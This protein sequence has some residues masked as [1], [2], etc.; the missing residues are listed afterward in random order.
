VAAR[1]LPPLTE[2]AT[3]SRSQL[4]DIV[5]S[6]SVEAAPTAPRGPAGAAKPPEERER[7]ARATLDSP[8][9]RDLEATF[10]LNLRKALDEAGADEKG[11]EAGRVRVPEFEGPFSVVVEIDLLGLRRFT[12]RLGRSAAVFVRL[13]FRVLPRF[14]EG[15]SLP[16]EGFDGS[17]IASTRVRVPHGRYVLGAGA[18]LVRSAVDGAPRWWRRETGAK[19]WVRCGDPAIRLPLIELLPRDALWGPFP[20][21][22]T[23]K[24]LSLR[25]ERVVGGRGTGPGQFRMPWDIAVNSA[26]DVIVADADNNRLQVL[27]RDRL[28][29]KLLRKC[30]AF[31]RGVAVDAKDC[32]FATFSAR[33]DVGVY[34]FDSQW[35]HIGIFGDRGN[36]PGEFG[37]PSGVCARRDGTV[38]VADFERHVVNVYTSRGVFLF[39]FGGKGAEDGHFARA[40]R[41][42]ETPSGTLVVSEDGA[43][44]RGAGSRRASFAAPEASLA[45]RTAHSSWPTRR[46][47]VCKCWTPT[48]RRSA[49][50]ARRAQAMVSLTSRDARVS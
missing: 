37:V 42:Q 41:V 21:L 8:A 2:A 7:E 35:K 1:A 28:E 29:P 18:L 22:T 46:T 31:V 26:G 43:A 6:A 34:V 17:R 30:G 24:R 20:R 11:S 32:V 5:R 3:L 45:A 27:D 48:E 47:T 23:L 25:W 14:E 44:S 33:E 15:D 49:R 19:H 10:D 12:V 16:L 13:A 4:F 36:S 50:W 38:A 40:W 39:A 9:L